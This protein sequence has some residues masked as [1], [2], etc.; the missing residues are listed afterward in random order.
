MRNYATYLGLDPN[1]V[2][3]LFDKA[4][5]QPEA[6][7]EVVPAITDLKVRSHWAPNFAII[8]FMVVVSAIVFAWMYSAY[9]QQ[10]EAV[11]TRTIGV[12]TVTP[13]STSLM[14]S[15]HSVVSGRWFQYGHAD[16]VR[17][18]DSGSDA[19]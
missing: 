1:T 9:F 5:G 10:S 6:K 2:I 12:A 16:P 8:A 18:S 7:P 19:N 3:T 4:S 14:D 11:A 17:R 13:V 15:R